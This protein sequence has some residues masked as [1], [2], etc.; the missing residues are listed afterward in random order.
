M[1]PPRLLT[2]V[3][4]MLTLSGCFHHDDD[5]N[6]RPTISPISDKTVLV[7]NRS[8]TIPFS[9]SDPE[10]SAERLTVTANSNN[11]SLL[12][13]DNIGLSG[14]STDHALVLAPVDGMTGMARI[15]VTVTDNAGASTYT[16]FVLTVQSSIGSRAIVRDVYGKTADS[17]PIVVTHVEVTEDSDDPAA[18]DDLLAAP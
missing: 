3:A 14:T 15:T 18:F 13:N 5:D 1:K 7:D 6:Q 12:P 16:Q 10:T 11:T 9:V 4:L 8:E 2:N 17:A